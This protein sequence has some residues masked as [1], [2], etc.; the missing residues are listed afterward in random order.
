MRQRYLRAVDDVPDPRASLDQ[1]RSFLEARGVRVYPI[2]EKPDDVYYMNFGHDLYA[3]ILSAYPEGRLS[4][5]AETACLD[6][7]EK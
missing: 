7:P 5:S 4:M 6:N 3:G 1:A 2:G